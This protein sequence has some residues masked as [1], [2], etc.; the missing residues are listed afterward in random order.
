[1][2]ASTFLFSI[3]RLFQCE[4]VASNHS[5]IGKDVHIVSSG[6]QIFFYIPINGDGL[7]FAGVFNV[8]LDG[9]LQIA[10][11]VFECVRFALAQDFIA[12]LGDAYIEGSFAC[13]C[14]DVLDNGERYGQLLH[15][16][17]LVCFFASFVLGLYS[18]VGYIELC[19]QSHLSF[20]FFF[21]SAKVFI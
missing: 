19:R 13:L 1:M 4:G 16:L 2:H 8:F 20:R 15:V 3:L 12:R 9:V 6:R 17:H 11:F 14:G 18:D 10:V 5:A 7:F 21:S